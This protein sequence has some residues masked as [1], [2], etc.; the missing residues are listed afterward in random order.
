MPLFK[1]QNP[2]RYCEKL[3]EKFASINEDMVDSVLANSNLES[4]E[5]FTLLSEDEK[6]HLSVSSQ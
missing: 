6:A 5:R 4:Y 3:D 2:I 1:K